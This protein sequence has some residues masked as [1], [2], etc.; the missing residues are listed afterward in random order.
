MI[1][2]VD[3]AVRLLPG[4]DTPS[5]VRLPSGVVLR[6]S[7]LIPA[8]GGVLSGMKTRAAA[9]T[10]GRT[11]LIH[12]EAAATERLIYHELAHVR[13]WERYP[14]TFPFRYIRAHIRHGY[15]DNPYERDARAAEAGP[16]HTG[17]AI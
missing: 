7:R 17:G 1:G 4:E 16:G 14:I 8:V 10:L 15:R 3:A 13:Q 12:P 6:R 11:I 2:I 5:P 9:V